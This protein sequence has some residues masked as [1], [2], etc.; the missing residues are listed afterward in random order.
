MFTKI[1]SAIRRHKRIVKFLFSGVSAAGLEY[2]VFLLLEYLTD[3]PTTV[4]QAISFSCGLVVSFILNK[5][6]VFEAKSKSAYK[7]EA[8]LFLIVGF[9]NLVITT[10]LIGVLS[11]YMAAFIAKFILMA[12]VA[13]WNYLLFKSVIFKN[14]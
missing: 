12:C 4:S 9:S 5:F 2:V 6:W 8:I 13:T 14:R 7:R 11:M 10:A 3:T 1:S